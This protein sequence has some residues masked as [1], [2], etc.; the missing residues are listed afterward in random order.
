VVEAR[1]VTGQ[2]MR[3]EIWSDVVCPWC[4]IG[5]R[6]FETALGRFAHREQVKVVWRSFQLDPSAPARSEGSLDELLAK[7]YGR[8]LAE[9]AAMNRRVTD[10]AA[11]EGLSYRLDLARPGNTFDAHRLIHVAAAHG[12][13]DAAEERLMRAYF[14]EGVSIGDRERLVEISAEIGLDADEARAVLAG[15][16]YAAEVEADLRRAAAFGITGV[17]FFVVDERYGISGA[18]PPELLLGA[19]EQAWADS[20]PLTLVGSAADAACDDGSCAVPWAESTENR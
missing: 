11:A 4:Y 8:S 14:T 16:Q 10:Q 18:Q 13:Q 5:K 1:P 7:K 2:R 3:V 20:H 19:L 17:P 12:L 6:R 15:G 9:A